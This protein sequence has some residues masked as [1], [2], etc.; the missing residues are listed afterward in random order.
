MLNLNSSVTLVLFTDIELAAKARLASPLD[1]KNPDFSF[2]TA[3]ISIPFSISILAISACG[4]PSNTSKKVASS[5]FF[6]SSA[7]A[8]PNKIL[9]A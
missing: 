7:V 1:L 4:T 6:Q 3:I 2:K 8:F 9:D 5:R